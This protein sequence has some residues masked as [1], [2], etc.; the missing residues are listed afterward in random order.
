MRRGVSLLLVAI[1]AG[2]KS[3]SDAKRRLEY[4]KE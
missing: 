3:E 2:C 4:L 1:K